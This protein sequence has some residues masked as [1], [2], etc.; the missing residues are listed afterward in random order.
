[1][2]SGRFNGNN[3]DPFRTGTSETSEGVSQLYLAG[4]G[5]S[6]YFDIRSVY[7][8]GFSEV[9]QQSILPVIHP[10]LDYSTVLPQQIM[11]GELSYKVNLTSLS[12]DQASFDATNLSAEGT[13]CVNGAPLTADFG[14][15]HQGQL[16]AARHSGRLYASL[17]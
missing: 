7:Y 14:I 1:M 13:A 3:L 17:V 16:R 4:R 9:D 12:R 11:G 2:D 15:T 8:T 10:V 6:S 5:V